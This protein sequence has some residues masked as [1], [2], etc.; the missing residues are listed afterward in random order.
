MKNTQTIRFISLQVKKK[1]SCKAPL[2]YRMEAMTHYNVE[3]NCKTKSVSNSESHSGKFFQMYK[4]PCLEV[5]KNKRCKYHRQC[6]INKPMHAYH[7]GRLHCVLLSEALF[8]EIVENI[9]KV[10][11]FDWRVPKLSFGFVNTKVVMHTHFENLKQKQKIALS[12]IF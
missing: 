7:N 8:Y 2:V 11:L 12:K 6:Y 5:G 10:I 4:V 3:I 1:P 9:R